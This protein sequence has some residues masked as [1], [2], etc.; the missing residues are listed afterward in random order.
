MNFDK[1]ARYLES[2][3]WAKKDGE[4]V[5]CGVSDYAQDSLG[6][7]VFVELPELGSSFNKGDAFGVVE[8][9]KA[10]SDVYMPI[11]GEIVEING[12]LEDSPETVNSDPFGAGWLIKVKPSNPD[13]LEALLSA[14]D[15][16]R[17]TDG[18]DS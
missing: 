17:F 3:E 5:A 2:H 8:S 4:L 7:I 1:D 9:V 12:D 16:K 18:L 10:A 14:D 6:D 15:Y 11:S 13:E